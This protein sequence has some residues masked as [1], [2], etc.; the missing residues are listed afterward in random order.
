MAYPFNKPYQ[1]PSRSNSKDIKNDESSAFSLSAQ[2]VAY[3]IQYEKPTGGINN[4]QK[5]INS[6]KDIATAITPQD[7]DKQSD[8]IST[9]AKSTTDGDKDKGGLDLYA[10]KYAK[11]QVKG[12]NPFYETSPTAALSYDFVKAGLSAAKSRMNQ[13]QSRM[14]KK[15]YEGFDSMKDVRQTKREM[16]K[17]GRLNK[18]KNRKSAQYIKKASK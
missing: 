8:L 2:Q 14:E 5:K 9:Q 1:Q 7:T 12:V 6:A 17:E 11:D 18:L 4:I 13:G 15:G 10:D 3:G 16:N